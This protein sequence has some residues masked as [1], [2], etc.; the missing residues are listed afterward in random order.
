MATWKFSGTAEKLDV[1]PPKRFPSDVRVA[2][3]D[4]LGADVGA[5]IRNVRTYRSYWT[6]VRSGELDSV[7][8]NATVQYIKD[9]QVVFEALY[10]QWDDVTIPVEEFENLLSSYATFLEN[11]G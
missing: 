4:W 6:K 8:G 9:D 10:D 7:S 11:R 1:D 5:S 2:V 3:L